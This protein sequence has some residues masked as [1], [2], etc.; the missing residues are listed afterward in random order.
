MAPGLGL[1]PLARVDEQ[2]GDLAPGSA[3][4]E[5]A[6]ILLVTG[7]IG[8]DEAAGFGREIA[9]GDV[10]GDALLALGG[11]PVE[12]QREIERLALGAVAAR[13]GGERFELVVEQ[14]AAI[15]E[16]PADQGRLAVVDAAAG[17]EPEQ[18]LRAAVG[19]RLGPGG[20]R[21]PFGGEG[22]DQK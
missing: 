17:D 6:G 16:Q 19:R 22:P 14:Q 10:D 21:R 4:D 5:V 2:H 13:V 1:Q 9:P 8:D 7:R 15:V 11:Q 12:Q 18:R 3:G 20:A